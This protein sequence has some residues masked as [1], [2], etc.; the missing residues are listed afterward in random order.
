M[1][2][3][4]FLAVCLLAALSPVSA[5]ELRRQPIPFTVWLDFH[6]L[7]RPNAPRLA[8]P[9]WL[10]SVMSEHP[11]RAVG[12]PLSTIFRLRLRRMGA[13]NPEINLRL[14]FEDTPLSAPRITG[15]TE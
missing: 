5:Q 4:L 10:E 12:D 2:P 9:I 8:L 15:W 3:F 14:F 11:R 13:L 7:A 6:A 1:R